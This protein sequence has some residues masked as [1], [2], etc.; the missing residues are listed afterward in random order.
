MVACERKYNRRFDDYRV[1]FTDSSLDDGEQ[2]ETTL[3]DGI[4]GFFNLLNSIFG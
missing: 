3:F 2:G 4:N 1:Y